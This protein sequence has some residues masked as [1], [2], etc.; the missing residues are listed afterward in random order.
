MQLALSTNTATTASKRGRSCVTIRSRN[1][2]SIP[3]AKM[4]FSF[5]AAK[6]S[7][8]LVIPAAV[9]SLTSSAYAHA[10]VL[11]ATPPSNGVLSGP[12]VKVKL[13]FNSRID[14]H[15][16]RL[17]LVLPDGER[18]TLTIDDKSAPDS[19]SSNAK[20]LKVG[21][22]ILRWQVLAEDGHITRGEVPFRVR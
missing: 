21:N 17:I 3:L 1:R 14:L 9:S 6:R 13:R 19:L 7:Y 4:F 12:D 15:R 18:R 11:S 22:Y 8:I 5:L 20:E 10:I 2:N 16:S